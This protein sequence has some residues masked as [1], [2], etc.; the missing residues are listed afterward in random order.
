MLVALSRHAEPYI[1]RVI[2]ARPDLAPDLIERLL[3]HREVWLT[4]ARSH[5]GSA[6]VLARC[7]RSKN[8]D[9]GQVAAFARGLDP[10]LQRLLAPEIATEEGR[11]SS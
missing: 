10:E 5:Y 4:T 9:W 2:G 8:P 1:R 11:L 7:A 3:G 6:E